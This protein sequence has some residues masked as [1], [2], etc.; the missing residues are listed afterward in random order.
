MD[1]KK[2]ITW[3]LEGAFLAALAL[4]LVLF[5][6][7]TRSDGQELYI[8]PGVSDA[9]GWDIYILEDG[10]K[11][12]IPPSGL[13]DREGTVYLE[14]VIDPMWYQEGYTYLE[15]FGH[16]RHFS[17]FSDGALFYTTTPGSGETP[18]KAVFPDGYAGMN[19]VG[20]PVRCALPPGSGGGVLTIA[21][22]KTGESGGIGITL[23]SGETSKGITVAL[24]NRL[25]MPAAAFG[26]TALGL[27]GLFL[28][29]LS[30]GRRDWPLL[31][32]ALAAAF[33]CLYWLRE[34]SMRLID[35]LP[36][37]IPLAMFFPQ[38]FILG[39]LAF[40]T[41]QMRRWRWPCAIL[42]G[43]CGAFALSEPFLS[44]FHVVPWPLY[45]G[46]L[47]AAIA[48]TLVFA[49]LERRRG[50]QIF[51]AFFQAAGLL[52]A[53]FFLCCPLL[54]ELGDHCSTAL[55]YAFG[56]DFIFLLQM[57]GTGV[58]LVCAYVSA[59]QVI[60]KTADD[61]TALELLTVRE[62]LTRENLRVVQESAAAL[63]QVRH[64]TLGN[65]NILQTLYQEGKFDDLEEYLSRLTQRIDEIVPL[66][67]ANHPI[68]NAILTL[69]A[70][71]ARDAGVEFSAQVL[72]P[73]TLSIPDEDLAAFL[74][75]LMNNALDAAEQVPQGGPRWVDVTMR[76]RKNYLFIQGRNAYA[77]PPEPD[78]E[79]R[80]FRS[81]KGAGHGYGFKIMETTARRYQGE[82]QTE[83]KNGVFTLR[84][85][86]FLPPEA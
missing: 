4:T 21:T 61:Q 43:L 57:L 1:K 64:D 55:R 10:K 31:L 67:F 65:L 7:Y 32:L 17:L 51:F 5:S 18:E 39:S 75:N 25:G 76:V 8:S 59:H 6:H 41:G 60:R 53:A 22:R 62:A 82:L 35:D 86:L 85:A 80:S 3:T 84:T 27:L 34:F 56:G 26:L 54:P 15:L 38:F 47:V 46:S 16:E 74:M 12:A 9:A 68:V 40:L 77:T 30:R 11:R 20:E 73:K 81:R 29:A 52:C 48:V 28:Y 72:L 66:K 78:A 42:V 79:H 49:F 63:A 13:W 69:S 70:R 83:A 19:V 58:F 44:R 37:N 50:N 71:R 2:F 23:T 33:Q 24:A 14:R 36:L 45:S